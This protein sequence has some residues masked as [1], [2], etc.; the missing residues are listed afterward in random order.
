MAFRD[1]TGPGRAVPQEAALG[2]LRQQPPQTPIE[3]RA[4][5]PEHFAGNPYLKWQ[6]NSPISGKQEIHRVVTCPGTQG[7]RLLLGCVPHSD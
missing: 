6:D 3:M 2:R 5:P 7:I 4:T 1:P